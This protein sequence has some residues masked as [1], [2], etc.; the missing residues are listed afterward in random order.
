MATKESVLSKLPQELKLTYLKEITQDFSDEQKIGTGSFGTVY[1]GTLEDGDLIAVKKLQANSPLGRDKDFKTKVRDVMALKH[2]NI[3]K[4]IGYCREEQTKSVE[5]S[6]RYVHEET[7]ETLL[8]YE[9]S[10]KGSLANYIYDGHDIIDWDIRFKIIK[11]ICQGL[12]F[13]H[14]LSVPIIHMDLKPENLLMDERMV[15]K[16]ADF[17]LARLFGEKAT[18]IMT[19]N[20][21]GSYGYIAPEYRYSGQ[22]SLQ[23]DI[24][25]LGILIMEITT[26]EKNISNDKDLPGMQYI[27]NVRQ[28]WTEEHIVSKYPKLDGT[29]FHE[30]KTCIKIGVEC[31]KLQRKERPAINEIVEWLNG[32]R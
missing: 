8:C 25:S 10:P 28:I 31:V 26:G 17:G 22:V 32:T 3:V 27:E 21:M 1:K 4:M 11:A 23:A 7:V 6:G 30:V 24:Y 12:L 16:I 13:L 2:E 9:Y 29:R 15:P 5:R 19:Q 14:T 18:H 20:V